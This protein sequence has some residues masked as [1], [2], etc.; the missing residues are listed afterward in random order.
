MGRTNDGRMPASMCPLKE[1]IDDV[2]GKG[3]NN[4]VHSEKLGVGFYKLKVPINFVSD[5]D[6]GLNL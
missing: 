6:D 1:E 5:T 3:W 4:L 2:L